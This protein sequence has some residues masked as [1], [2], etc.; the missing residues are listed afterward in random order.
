MIIGEGKERK[1]LEALIGSL[2]LNTEVELVGELSHSKV[3]NILSEDK[4]DI[5]V[6]PSITLPLEKRAE[7][8]PVALMEAMAN[9][10]PVISTATGGKPELLGDNSK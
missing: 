9:G 8:I 3:I 10:I 6:L 1:E 4:I 5:L 2:K 7:G